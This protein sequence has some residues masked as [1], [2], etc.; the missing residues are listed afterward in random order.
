MGDCE[1][2]G[3]MKVS[4]R[5]TTA[6]RAMVEACLRCIE[7][8]GLNSQNDTPSNTPSKTPRNTK[9]SGGYGGTGKRGKDIMIQR[10]KELREDFAAVIKK[11]RIDHGFEQKELA[12]RMA[13]RVNII[14]NTEG[15]KRPTDTVLKKFERILKIQL[16]TTRSAEEE[17]NVKKSSSG[18]SMTLADYFDEAKKDL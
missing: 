14:Q 2:C 1:L 5:K 8:S 7:R 17:R 16:W 12:K 10:E 4:T 13:E 3:A 15:G 6:G 9:T 11:A 18:R